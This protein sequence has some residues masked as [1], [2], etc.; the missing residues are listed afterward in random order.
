VGIDE[1]A[2][3]VYRIAVHSPFGTGPTNAYVLRGDRVGLFD[4]GPANSIAREDLLGGLG[5]LGLAPA[6]VDL[7][8]VS[9]GHVDHHGLADEFTAARVVTGRRE[10]HKLTDL[11]LH[12]EQYMSVAVD[13]LVSW[14][15]PTK[16]REGVA[17][18]ILGLVRVATSLPGAQPVDEGCVLDGFGPPF[19]VRELPGHTEGLIGLH[20]PYDGVLLAGDHLLPDITPN[21]GLYTLETP[22]RSGL[23]DYVVSLGRVLELEPTI[24]LPGHGAP[25]GDAA[26]RVEEV[27]M[28]HRERLEVVR[29][30]AGSGQTVFEIATRLFPGVE[31][32]HVFL[33]GREVYGH[34]QILEHD[35]RVSSSVV[36]GLDVFEAA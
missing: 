36:A 30:A 12:L 32:G 17:E 28:H 1:V 34:L 23:A 22:P 29:A 8:V 5:R 25:F 16:A 2:D 19:V 14:G 7:V 11:E 24:V 10:V 18:F 27:L 9:H 15:V 33:A 13:L 21:P 35:G 4:T 20:R 6:D 26:G 31:P 3:G